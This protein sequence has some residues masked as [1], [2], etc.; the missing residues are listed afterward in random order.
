MH[1]LSR[2]RLS[3][4]IVLVWAV[5]CSAAK[6]Q[7]TE[8]TAPGTSARRGFRGVLR[9]AGADKPLLALVTLRAIAGACDVE[10]ST[11][12]LRYPGARDVSPLVGAHPGRP[13]LYIVKGAFVVFQSYAAWRARH[14]WDD[15]RWTLALT[16]ALAVD[17]AF[18]AHNWQLHP[19]R[20]GGVR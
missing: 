11:Q 5:G 1:P 19:P 15:A 18:A 7:S 4:A 16:P 9:A 3:L 14:T 17:G 2:R 12:A 20:A 13:R 10:A 8:P 6:G